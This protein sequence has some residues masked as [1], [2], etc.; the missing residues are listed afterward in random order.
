MTVRLPDDQATELETVAAVD[1]LPVAEVIRVAVAA[2][3]ENR[4]RDPQFQASLRARIER[5]RRLLDASTP[6]GET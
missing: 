3:I 2:H 5:D 1:G 6:G 4:K